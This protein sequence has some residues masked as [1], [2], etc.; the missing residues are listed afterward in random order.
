MLKFGFR[1]LHFYPLMLLLFTFLRRS[2]EI[3]LKYYI[4]DVNIEFIIPFLIFFSQ[5]LFGGI[6]YLYYIK[7]NISEED[8]KHNILSPFKIGE[9][10]F[11]S[12][13]SHSN[14]FSKIKKIILILFAS[15]FNSIGSLIRNDDLIIF[16]IVEDKNTQLE[17]KV[18]S[19]QIIISS[20]LCIYAIRFNIYQ[21]QKISLIII[22]FFFVCL[23]L[24][25]LFFSVNKISKILA[26][27]FCFMSCLSRSFLDVTEKYLFD[28][29][30]I[31]IFKMLLFEGLI[32]LFL[33]IINFLTNKTY[34]SQG[35]ILLKDMARLDIT[36]ILFILL[37]ILYI[38]CS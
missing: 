34:Q 33:F 20:L 9:I 30:F 8:N 10:K 12:N 21:H 24:M 13:K 7:K 25:E 19:I 14:K 32:G 28:F 2:I 16:K 36:L 27:L 15:F 4:Y 6:I 29:D 37:I 1:K 38:I 31:N 5:S 23:I 18:R 17:I 26:L 11:V 3:V 35:K 22:S